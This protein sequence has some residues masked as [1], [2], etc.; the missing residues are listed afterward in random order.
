[1]VRKFLIS[2]NTGKQI[3]RCATKAEANKIAKDAAKMLGWLNVMVKEIKEVK[4]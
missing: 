2:Y 1:M 3:V 4:A